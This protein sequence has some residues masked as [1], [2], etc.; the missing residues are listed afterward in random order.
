MEKPL[1][2]ATDPDCPWFD[3]D[4]LLD[5][6]FFPLDPRVVTVSTNSKEK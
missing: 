2:P 5:H 3:E 6:P 4:W 1:P